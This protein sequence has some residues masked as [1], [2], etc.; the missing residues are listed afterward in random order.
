M[1]PLFEKERLKDKLSSALPESLDKRIVKDIVSTELSF[2][3]YL[4][5]ARQSITFRQPNEK[6]NKI[7]LDFIDKRTYADILEKTDEKK[8]LREQWQKFLG[9]DIWYPYFKAK[10]VEDWISDKTKV[11]L[12]HFKGRIRLENNQIKYTFKAQF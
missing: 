6:T 3:S 8:V 12:F 2:P 10:E 9:I 7:F 5:P 1:P 4:I 11:E